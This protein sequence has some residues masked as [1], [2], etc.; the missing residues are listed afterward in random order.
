VIVPTRQRPEL[1]AR[2]VSS[3]LRQDYAGEVE[4]LVVFDQ[5]EPT[6]PPV[7]ARD[8]REVKLLTNERSPGLA[9]GRNTGLL[10]A[11]GE[12]V[13][14][15]DD[16][17]EWLPDKL[18]WQ[19]AALGRDP[20]AIVAATGIE[21]VYEGR[22]VPRLPPVD[23]VPMRMLLRSRMTELHP[24]TFLARREGLLE[25]DGDDGLIDEALPGSYG[26][27][28]DWLLR[29]ARRHPIVAVRRPLVRVHWHASSFFSQRWTMIIEALQYLLTR[30][31][32]FALEPDGLA[33]IQGQIAFA[34]AAAGLR[35]DARRWARSALRNNWRERRAYVALLVSTGL[36][37]AA[38]VL[39][40]AHRFGRGI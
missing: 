25:Q 12:L 11:T 35:A 26:E 6:P 31:P 3:I 40:W 13:A 1:L 17:D 16:D 32:E 18:R 21:V 15:C 2:A 20:A 36:V 8:G 28:Y 27:D 4:C 7:D 34:S 10:A 30:Y 29:A 9:G 37:S 5:E 23:R 39:R 24:S 38:T 19:V 14:F 33:R 22:S